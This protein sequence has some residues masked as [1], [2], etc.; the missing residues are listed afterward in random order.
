MLNGLLIKNR[1]VRSFKSDKL[2][3]KHLEEM[4][5]A[6]RYC[7]SAQNLQPLKYLIACSDKNSQI[8]LN[9]VKFGGYL[10]AG[11]T[12]KAG[13]QAQNFI[14]ICADTSVSTN[15]NCYNIDAGIAAQTITLKAT[16]MGYSGCML[17]SFNEQRLS[18]E[19]NL[20]ENLVPVLAIALGVG[21][22]ICK[23]EDYSGSIK[24]YRA[25]GKHIV[26]KRNLKD[27]II[28]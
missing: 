20:Q 8:I 9:N 2:P 7:A 3:Y 28:K 5:A 25:C 4:V 21:D 22:E 13:G 27:I 24:Y 14:L 12:P 11:T 16:E 6:T 1:S 19:L 26:P 15:Q 17:K 23:T 18:A 10:P